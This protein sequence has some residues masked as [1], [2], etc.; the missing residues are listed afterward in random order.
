MEEIRADGAAFHIDNAGLVL[1]GPFLPRFFERLGMTERTDGRP[2]R[3]KSPEMAERAVHL[4]Q[5]LVTGQSATPEPLLLVN[6]VLCGL[7]L[8]SPVAPEIEMTA[9]EVEA[10]NQ[11]LQAILTN[12]KDVSRSSVA[13]LRET[14]LQRE[15][16]LEHDDDRYKLR[17]QRKTLDVLVDQIP[18][19]FSVVRA[20]WMAEPLYVTW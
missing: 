7:D 2:D 4:L 9:T 11:L 10:G 8:A 14:F 3:W 6:K 13:A 17:V 1:T 5:W 15:G 16:R 19:S 18:W 12:W 20:P